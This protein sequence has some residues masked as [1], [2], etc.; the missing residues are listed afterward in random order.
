[1]RA[2]EVIERTYRNAVIWDREMMRWVR[3][4]RFLVLAPDVALCDASVITGAAEALM[5]WHVRFSMLQHCS[6]IHRRR[7][8]PRVQ[9]AKAAIAG[10]YIWNALFNRVVFAVP[11]HVAIAAFCYRAPWSVPKSLTGWNVE[12]RRRCKS[13]GRTHQFYD[14]FTG[15]PTFP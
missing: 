1:M 8:R 14:V 15:V 2:V 13:G 6:P 11:M 7:T 4:D 12:T 9:V 5:L 3:N 10:Q